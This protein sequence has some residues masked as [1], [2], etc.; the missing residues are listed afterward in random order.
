MSKPKP[1]PKSRPSHKPKFKLMPKSKPSPKSKTKPKLKPNE[2][3]CVSY[4]YFFTPIDVEIIQNFEDT[5]RNYS[6]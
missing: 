1:S 5:I 6:L 4:I 3:I 2:E